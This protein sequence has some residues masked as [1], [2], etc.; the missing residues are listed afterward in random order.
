MF[1]CLERDRE[2]EGKLA[3]HQQDPFPPLCVTCPVRMVECFWVMSHQGEE[4]GLKLAKP[5]LLMAP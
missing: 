5:S 4:G 2:V 3:H 1:L